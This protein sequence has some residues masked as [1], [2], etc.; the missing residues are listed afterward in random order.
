MSK[1]RQA[2]IIEE[3][4]R[5]LLSD[6]REAIEVDAPFVYETDVF[7]GGIVLSDSHQFSIGRW[8]VRTMG[9]RAVARIEKRSSGAGRFESEVI[10]VEFE[11]Q[12]GAVDIED[13][14]AYQGRGTYVQ[15]LRM[16]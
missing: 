12:D 15:D 14:R 10:E 11:L 3:A 9:K 4:L 7:S 1:T 16:D 5:N 8:A 2:E 6:Q 13:W